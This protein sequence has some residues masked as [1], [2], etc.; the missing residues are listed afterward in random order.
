MCVRVPGRRRQ[1]AARAS[2]S[3][4]AVGHRR[5]DAY[6]DRKCLRT[7]RLQAFRLDDEEDEDIVDPLQLH[8]DADGRGRRREA[9]RRRSTRLPRSS[10]TSSVRSP[11]RLAC[12]PRRAPTASSSSP[13]FIAQARYDGVV[14]IAIN[15]QALDDLPPDADFGA[16]P[17]PVT[18]TIDP[19]AVFTL[20]EIALRGDAARPCAGRIRAHSR[21][22]TPVRTRSS[23]PK[24]RSCGA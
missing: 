9:S 24:P 3:A 13:R 18:I 8:R 19:G 11:D 23:R 16:G 12:W 5:H 14:E 2:C 7:L 10:R 21:A 17:V 1:G 6:A 22:A 15:G 4:P 20:G